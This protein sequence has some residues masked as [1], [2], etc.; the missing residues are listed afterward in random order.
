MLI[1]SDIE[2]VGRMDIEEFPSREI[3]EGLFSCFLY[4]QQLS[5]MKPSILIRASLR[6]KGLARHC[7]S[8]YRAIHC[9]REDNTHHS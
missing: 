7:V 4:H 9:Q 2:D 8:D 3:I 6:V 5:A 1:A